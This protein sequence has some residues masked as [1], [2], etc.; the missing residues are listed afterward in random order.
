MDN[1]VENIY[2]PTPYNGQYW[3]YIH[4]YADRSEGPTN[5]IIRITVG[6]QSQTFTG[7]IET[8]DTTVDVGGFEYGGGSDMPDMDDVLSELQAGVGEITVSM[9]W[10]S[11]DDLDLHMQTPDGSE[12]YY[13]N[14]EAGGGNL[15]VDANTSGNMM[16]NPVENI[17]FTSPEGG[18]YSIWI[19]DYSDR[20]DGTTNYVV[21]VT[22]GDQSQ[23][24]T[25]TID[26]SSSR[27]DITS[28][29]YG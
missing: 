12:I 28:F 21:R 15:D 23:Q 5:Y 1:P 26:G 6:G 16:A 24:F 18:E 7:T 11:E 13:G 2:F 10:D 14:R 3:V 17:Y 22:V 29:S 8:S 20:S 4:D 25:G 27:Q 19:I 9:M